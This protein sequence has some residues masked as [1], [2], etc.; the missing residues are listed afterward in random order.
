MLDSPEQV[1]QCLLTCVD[2]WQPSTTSILQVG[3]ARRKTALSDG[4]RDGLLETLDE[5]TELWRRV[6][7]LAERDRELLLLWYVGQD[8]AEDI[9]S[10]LRI[11][12]RQ[13]FRRKAHAIRKIVELGDEAA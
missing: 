1:I 12:R 4:F 6:S 10:T 11:S 3:K 9:A 5:R 8:S 7:Q 13:F 2:W